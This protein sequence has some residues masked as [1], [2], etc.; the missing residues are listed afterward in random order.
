MLVKA[1]CGLVAI[2]D[3]TDAIERVVPVRPASLPM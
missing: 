3:A 1:V 2:V